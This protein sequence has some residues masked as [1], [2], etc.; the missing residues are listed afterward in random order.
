MTKFE[1]VPEERKPTEYKFTKEGLKSW[2]KDIVETAGFVPLEVR[3]KQ[4]EQAGYRARFF[5]SEFT[6]KDVTDMYLNHPE[7]DINPEDDVE[8]MIEKMELRA[9]YIQYVKEQVRKR[10]AATDSKLDESKAKIERSESAADA[11]EQ[12]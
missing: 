2:S 5:E 6:S 12:N 9:K 11:A 8:D 3:F 4:M 1:W 10:N 7:F